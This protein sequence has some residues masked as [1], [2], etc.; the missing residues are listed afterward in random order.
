MA[1]RRSRGFK[2]RFGN[3]SSRSRLRTV[4]PT[5]RWSRGNFA[6]SPTLT[7]DGP[8]Q[9]V[10]VVIP[11]A[12][13]YDH[14][15]GGTNS[16]ARFTG[17]ELV[18]TMEVGGVVFDAQMWLLPQGATV[19]MDAQMY[20]QMLL[21]SDRLDDVGNPVALGGNFFTNTA[22]VVLSTAAE[23]QDNDATFPTRVHWRHGAALGAQIAQSDDITNIW[24][25]NPVG[26]RTQWSKSLRLRLRLDDTTG[27]NFY[28]QLSTPSTYPAIIGVSTDV[29]FWFVGSIYYRIRT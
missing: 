17:N 28:A 25:P 5:Q 19:P 26:V 10:Q 2:P 14:V 29:Q 27:F 13:I 4:Q 8:N 3:R 16:A 24:V 21:C 11:L 22:P 23:L 7:V 1:F 6:L 15:F 18:R 20:G 9:N 12:Q